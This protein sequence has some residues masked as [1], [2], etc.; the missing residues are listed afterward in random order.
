[1]HNRR[2]FIGWSAASV[3]SV[4]GGRF[5]FA[6]DATAAKR[7]GFGFSLYGMKSL[8]LV[9]AIKACADIG[10]DCVEL[11]VMVDW[12]AAPEKLSPVAKQQLRESLANSNL[13]LSALMENLPLLGEQS[14]HANNLAR[15]RAAGA[16][17]HELSPASLPVI[18][19]VMGGRPEQ[20]DDVKATMVS[21]LSEWAK[22]AEETQTIVAIKAHVSNAAHR[23]EHLRWLLDEVRSP[24]LK[25]AFD[26]SHYQLQGIELKTAWDM[27]VDDV[28]FI[29]IKDTVGDSKKFRFVLPG[30]GGTNY[31]EYLQMIRDSSCKADVI[32]EVSGQI[33][34]QP[35]YDPIA[36]AKTSFE[37]IEPSFKSAGVG[38]D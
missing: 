11:P 29:H 32:V 13:R 3:A 21:R 7:I 23:P 16:L 34:S 14:I 25:A 36:A 26:F 30:D 28:V 2:R 19:T 27:L 35:D 31:S 15:L 37:A 12:P 22:I 1:M 17:A 18:E 5:S 9:D 24:W 10:Y 8:S 4:A 38:C 33:H 20:W 6:N